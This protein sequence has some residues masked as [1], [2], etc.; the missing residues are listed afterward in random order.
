MITDFRVRNISWFGVLLKWDYEENSCCSVILL[1]RTSDN[2]KSLVHYRGRKRQ[3][4]VVGLSPNTKYTFTLQQ[5]NTPATAK[6][7]SK[8]AA[9]PDIPRIR[10]ENCDS[11]DDDPT[12]DH[13]EQS[14][15][16][17]VQEQREIDLVEA[18][19]KHDVEQNREMKGE[20]V[21]ES[22]DDQK[23]IREL[24]VTFR[25]EKCGKHDAR[26]IAAI[27]NHDMS[28]VRRICSQSPEVISIPDKTGVTPMMIAAIRGY[29]SIIRVLLEAGANLDQPNPG[30]K[31]ALMLAAYHGH[32]HVITTLME[33]G[34]NWQKL[35]NAGCT[36]LHYCVE[37]GNIDIARTLL[38]TGADINT[39]DSRGYTCL[40]SL[41]LGDREDVEMAKFLLD[42]GA[43]PN[44]N[45]QKGESVLM[46]A[47]RTNKPA[48]T[49]L[50]IEYGATV[51]T[52]TRY[53]YTALDMAR[54]GSE[55]YEI[56]SEYPL[57]DSESEKEED[58]F[59]SWMS[60]KAR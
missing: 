52:K 55:C 7:Y 49:R 20:E 19:I 14:G 4:K 25:T 3:C 60:K 13:E 43:D 44:L 16:D 41:C 12:F 24:E 8:Q 11:Q 10:V 29:P 54:Q 15:V 53:G 9:G 27:E 22:G 34:C 51:K 23:R 21:G 17:I 33:L 47:T 48:L 40:L 50:L 31:T 57:E 37:R 26:L 28:E 46:A 58:D 45:L 18:S 32:N 42:N 1:E 6:E 30:G 5:D 36:A 39:P 2:S 35:D 59:S 38:D 56:I